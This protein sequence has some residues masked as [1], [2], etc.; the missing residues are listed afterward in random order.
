MRTVEFDHIRGQFHTQ[1][2]FQKLKE[3]T[4]RCFNSE[5]TKYNNK[6]KQK[7]FTLRLLASNTGLDAFHFKSLFNY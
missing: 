5:K 3:T 1:H 2:T 4:K 7:K 6:I